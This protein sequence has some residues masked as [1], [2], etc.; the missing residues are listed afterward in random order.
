M[1]QGE[2]VITTPVVFGRLHLLPIIVEF[3]QLY[4]AISIRL[5]QADRVMHLLDD[6][7]D[8]ALRIGELPDS[9]L[10]AVRLGQ[11]DRL[12]C[13]SPR[14]LEQQGTPSCL[15]DLA[16]PIPSI[17]CTRIRGLCH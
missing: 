13:A 14:Y 10:V 4:P 9:R 5:V 11:V 6:H 1:P 2:L 3:L 7:V 12:I 16:E 8:V 17:W 15:E